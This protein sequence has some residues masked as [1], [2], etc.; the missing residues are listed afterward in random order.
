MIPRQVFDSDHEQFR[1]MVIKFL[2]IEQSLSTLLYMIAAIQDKMRTIFSFLISVLPTAELI[3]HFAQN[4][5]FLILY[6][7]RIFLAYF[8]AY[9]YINGLFWPKTAEI[10]K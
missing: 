1:D 4:S 2:K 3:G 6:G 5:R 8:L 9:L 10:S 7:L